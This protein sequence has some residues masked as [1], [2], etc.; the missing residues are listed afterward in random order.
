MNTTKWSWVPF[1]TVG[2]IV[3]SCS[4]P[5]TADAPAFSKRTY[6][7]KTADKVEIQAD[8]HRHDDRVV[9]PVLVWLHGGAL[10]MGSRTHVPRNLIE[11]C[12]AEGFA[13]VSFDYRLAPEVK[14]PAI[15]EDVE[16]AF[17]WL[18][19]QGP[20]L[21]HVDT[22]RLV[23]AGGSAGG[24]LTLMT[25]LRVKPRP[26]ALVAYWG[27]GDV[28]GPWY[29]TPS[30][31]YRKQPLVSK[32]EAHKGVG[33]K[34][35]TGSGGGAEGKARGRYYLYLRQN[36]L[37]TREVTGFDPQKDRTKL[38]PYCPVR[39]VTTDYPPT[40][41][42]HGTEDTDVPYD[43]SVA[44]AKEFARHKVP[45]ELLTVRGS[46]HGLSGGNPRAVAN[47][48]RK[49]LDFI[50]EH[51]AAGW[52][53]T[54]EDL[55]KTLKPGFGGVSGVAVD[56]RSGDVY[57]SVSDCG[58]Y[59]STDQG[60]T[61]KLHGQAF[62][63][64]TEWPGALLI[65]PVGKGK[66]LVAATVYGAPIA[67][68][69]TDAERW[70][71]LDGK[72]SHVDWC[73]LDWTDPEGKFIL[74]LKHESGGLLIVSRDGGKTFADVGKG[75]G[76]AWVFDGKTAVVAELKTKDHPKP[77]LLRTTDAGKTFKPCGDYHALALP[78]WHAGTLFWL[79]GDTLIT[80]IDRGATW[81]KQGA[82]KG[83]RYGP[84]FG[85]DGKHMLVLTNA[86]I[87]ESRDGGATWSG[88]I[89]LP[90]ELKGVGPLSW[91]EY[92]PVHDV[93]YAMKMGSPLY[94]LR[95]KGAE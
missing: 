3:L 85:K 80:S 13:L 48:H 63:G 28:D 39:N 19:R 20:K 34:V 68:T 54:T 41:L 6:T 45:H 8:V 42:V 86:G 61:W 95:R 7:F 4:S 87:A 88:P 60:R 90:R 76:P 43:L 9:R 49:A 32:D 31:H 55:L 84:I 66:E 14:L 29:T 52:E 73:S 75:Y 47:A 57:I 23:V 67:R 16:D 82:V 94:R 30:E 36:G 77:G 79:A 62:K 74:A 71:F 50:R 69:S 89:A 33:G 5:A 35:L 2:A 44:M 70:K 24:Y 11:L 10:I 93:L 40:L 27:Y 22:S 81:R 18:H 59:R 58:V 21:L 25:G 12:R 64:R 92:D 83:A 72:S 53:P 1:L 65:D 51:L 38:D 15:I 26:R 78:K 91:M 56:H 37:W 17:R 46:G